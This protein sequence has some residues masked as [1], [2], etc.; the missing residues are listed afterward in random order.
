[1]VAEIQAENIIP[2]PVKK[3]SGCQDIGGPGTSLPPMEKKNK[4]AGITC[5]LARVKTKQ[6]DTVSRIDYDLACVQ[7]QLFLPQCSDF[8]TG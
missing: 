7:V 2:L 3:S 1:V 5:P 4:A 6:A 8:Q